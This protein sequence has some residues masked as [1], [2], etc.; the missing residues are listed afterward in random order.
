MEN[1]KTRGIIT[2]R[3]DYGES[4]CMLTILAEGM[5]VISACAYGVRS[6]RSKLKA[7]TQVLCFGEF[8]L[9]KKQGD[10]YRVESIEILDSFYPVCEDI[11]KLALANYL[12]E[13]TKEVYA[14]GDSSV[15]SLLLN[16]LYVLAYRDVDIGLAKAVFEL[17]LSKYSGYEPCMTMCINCGKSDSLSAFSFDGGMKCT[18]CKNA[19]DMNINSDILMAAKYILDAEDKKIFSF[20]VSESVKNGL[21]ILAESYILNKS[22]RTYKSLDYYKKLI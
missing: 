14:E 17:K 15:L 7:A 16:T 13:L 21:A 3:A 12:C 19:A 2:R 4:N 11:T 8:V 20:S 9:S 22:E 5:G 10:I 18:S 1:C 6:K